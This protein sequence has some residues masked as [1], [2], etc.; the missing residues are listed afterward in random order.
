MH[1][2]IWLTGILCKSYL[3]YELNCYFILPHGTVSKNTILVYLAVY[4][5]VSRII[6]LHLEHLDYIVTYL[7]KFNFI[8][9]MVVYS[10]IWT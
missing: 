3:T 8:W 7:N 9:E 5:A 4:L 10:E 6:I 2:L 1:P